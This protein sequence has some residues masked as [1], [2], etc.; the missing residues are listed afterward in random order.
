MFL[1][2]KILALYHNLKIF[3]QKDKAGHVLFR[4]YCSLIT[5]HNMNQSSAIKRNLT[6]PFDQE[7]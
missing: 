6:N 7:G 3:R 4:Q 5:I 1:Q 2:L